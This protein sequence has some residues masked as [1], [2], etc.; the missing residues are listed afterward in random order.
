[1]DLARMRAWREIYWIKP[2][3]SCKVVVSMSMGF[4][5]EAAGIVGGVEGFCGS[6]RQRSWNWALHHVKAINYL[7][8]WLE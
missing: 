1:M 8:C 2:V 3:L 4:I 7:K 6:W 5:R